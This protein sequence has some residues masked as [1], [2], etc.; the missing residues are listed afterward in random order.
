MGFRPSGSKNT[1]RAIAISAA[2]LTMMLA[3]QAASADARWLNGEQ[4]RV[5]VAAVQP[6]H[7]AQS[8]TDLAAR[9]DATRV[10]LQF[11]QPLSHDQR[12]ALGAA[13]VKL[14]NYVG[15]GVYF[16]NLDRNALDTN[17]VMATGVAMSGVS[18]IASD[19]KL[20]PLLIARNIP[21]YAVT[22]QVTTQNAGEF[23]T[24]GEPIVAAYLMLHRDANTA[25]GRAMLENHGVFIVDSIRSLNGFVIEAPLTAIEALADQDDVLWVEVALP[26]MSEMNIENRQVTQVNQL[27]GFPI[28]LS[29]AGVTAFV[30]DGGRVRPTHLDFEGRATVIDGSSQS[31]HATHVAGTV[32]GGGPNRGMAPDVTIVSAGFQTGGGGGIF[33]YTNPGDFEADYTNAFNNHNADVAN[34]SIGTNTATNG[35]PCEITGEYGLMASL[36]DGAVRGSLTNGSPIRVVWANGN[37]RQSTRCGNLFNT[38]A[39]PAG[40]KNHITVGAVNANNESMTTFS[41]WGP[42]NDGRIKPDISA[43]GCEQGGDGGVTSLSSSSD[44]AYSTLCGTSMASPTVAGIAALLIEHHRNLF[45][46]TADPR[47][48]TLKAI[49]AQT[50]ADLG[51][52]GPDYKFGYGSVRAADAALLMLQRNYTETEV[53]Q[54]S[55]AMFQVTVGNNQNFKATIAWDDFPAIPNVSSTLVNDLDLVVTDPSGVRH[56]PWTLDPSAPDNPAVRTQEDNVNNIE[57]VFVENAMPGTWIVEIRGT[58]VPEGPQSVSLATSGSLVGLSAAVQGGLPELISP[59]DVTPLSLSVIPSGQSLVSGSVQMHYRFAP[60]EAFTTVPMVLSAPFVYSADLPQAQCDNPAEFFFSL[61]GSLTGTIQ[62]PSGGADSPYSVP[63]GN[64]DEVFYDDFTEDLGWV[65]GAPDDDAD[66]GIWERVNPVGT[67][68]QPAGALFGEFC[69]VTGQHP[70]GGAGAN[71]VDNGKT[72]LFTPEFDLSGYN[73]GEL[74]I[75][76]WRWYSNSAGASP[77]NDIFE[78]DISNDGGLTWQI[79][80][81]VGPAGPQVNGGWFFHSFDPADLVTLTDQVKMRFVASD[82]DP[83]ALVEAAVDGFRIEA[84]TC[85]GDSPNCPGDVTGDGNVDLGDLNLVLANFG[86]QTSQGD[87]NGDGIVDLA[88]LNTVLANFGSSCN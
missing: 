59:T 41:S 36:I 5:P 12:Q 48:S 53:G 47:N 55:S 60:G 16:A 32:G 57:Q 71:D 28:N 84:R 76:Y 83:Q 54:S 2:A 1:R 6:G 37:E 33:L 52:P 78:V 25:A 26:Q 80:E 88:D 51:N 13:G 4:V 46:D 62:V 73:A 66:T 56:F 45:P 15:D 30:F 31:N 50:A 43:P 27:M 19:V 11:D 42:V 63:V 87:T 23:A 77:N 21:P 20:H 24:A 7:I 79:V 64:I 44:S 40:A 81:V 58:N 17:A 67:I 68:A 39:P 10:L 35:F 86:Q 72:T 34:N 3:G 38:T 85:V 82:Y 70:G 18:A 49:F 9:P 8:M 29:G 65:V 61:A 74:T 22:G 69:Y 14:L 75:S